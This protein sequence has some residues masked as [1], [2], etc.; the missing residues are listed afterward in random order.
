MVFA[1]RWRRR[2]RHHAGGPD[3]PGG[4]HGEPAQQAPGRE[5]EQERQAAGA[6]ALALPPERPAERRRRGAVAR[7]VPRDGEEG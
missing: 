3:R 6:A 2:R 1:A 4:R 5:G 7:P